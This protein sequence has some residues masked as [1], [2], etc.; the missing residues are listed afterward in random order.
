MNRKQQQQ[1]CVRRRWRFGCF[2]CAAVVLVAAGCREEI[3]VAFEENLVRAHQIHLKEGLDMQQTLSDANWALQRM[4]GTPD[5]PKLPAVLTEDE[6]LSNLLSME[7]LERAAGPAGAEGRGLYRQHCATCHGITGNGRGT[8]AA[9]LDPYPRDYR[10]GLFKFKSTARGAKPTK[11][12][13]ARVI[14][15][16]IPGTQMGKIAELTEQ[17]IQ[18]LTDYVIYLSIRLS[19]SGSV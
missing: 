8:T 18:A 9:L 4:F 16:G 11:E 2:A 5:D 3:P 13:I 6:D 12:D 7:H 1:L 15:D 19:G 14:R 17:D 10:M